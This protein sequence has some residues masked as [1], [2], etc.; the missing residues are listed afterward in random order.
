[1]VLVDTSIWVR[2]VAG[3]AP[4]AERLDSLLAKDEVIGHPFIFGE[5]LMGD[6]GGRTQFLNDYK[7]MVQT[8]VVP[9]E[10]VV[11]FVRQNR[12]YGRGVGWIDA[13][14]LAAAMLE[15]LPLWTADARLAAVADGL[16][17]GV[18]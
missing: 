14:L 2:F 6:R 15:G 4:F 10:D 17:L 7:R 12:L 11:T 3:Q 8:V 13:H 1:M 16:G 5:L 9:N 18:A